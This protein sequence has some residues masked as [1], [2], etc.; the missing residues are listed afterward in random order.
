VRKRTADDPELRIGDEAAVAMTPEL[1]GVPCSALG[2]V[3]TSLRQQRALILD[4]ID[5][6]LTGV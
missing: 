2:A 5:F 4:G 6:L 1:A 3:V